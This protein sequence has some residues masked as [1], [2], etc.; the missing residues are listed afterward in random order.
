MQRQNS[1][2]SNRGDAMANFTVGIRKAKAQEVVRSK[3]QLQFD[4]NEK[5]ARSSWRCHC[6]ATGD[7]ARNRT[8]ARYPSL[9]NISI[10]SVYRNRREFACPRVRVTRL[11]KNCYR[12]LADMARANSSV[13][14]YRPASCVAG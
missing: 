7:K 8:S 1:S 3:I 6:L 11:K 10:A 12:A 5:V 4:R 14:I 9:P 13:D 2:L